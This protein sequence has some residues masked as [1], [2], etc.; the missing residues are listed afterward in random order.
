MFENDIHVQTSLNKLGHKVWRLKVLGEKA[1]NVI[2]LPSHFIPTD[3]HP[4]TLHSAQFSLSSDTT[5]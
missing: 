1:V 5:R 3:S 4:S 2:I